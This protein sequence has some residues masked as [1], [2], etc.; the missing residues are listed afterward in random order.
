MFKPDLSTESPPYMPP[1]CAD[2]PLSKRTYAHASVLNKYQRLLYNVLEDYFHHRQDVAHRC[3]VL[4]EVGL[5]RIVQL[6]SVSRN[7]FYPNAMAVDTLIVDALTARP[8]AVFEADGP[9]HGDPEHVQHWRD[10]VKD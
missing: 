3:V 4:S 6:E 9:D 10:K 1:P 5:S 7:G 8:M 2:A